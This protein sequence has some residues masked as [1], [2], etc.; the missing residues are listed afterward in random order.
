MKRLHDRP[1]VAARRRLRAGD[2][3]LASLELVILLPA[4][5]ILTLLA[6]YLGRMNVAHTAVDGAAQDAARAASLQRDLATAETAATAAAKAALDAPDSPCV[7]GTANATIQQPPNPFAV[8]LGQASNVVV[9]V[10]CKVDVSNLAF[11]GLPI[12]SGQVT[13]PSTFVSPI[14]IHRVRTDS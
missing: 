7:H 5:I 9:T 14:D 11:P 2:A 8:A 10:T 4:F 1:L 3:G 6:G 13:V 12:P